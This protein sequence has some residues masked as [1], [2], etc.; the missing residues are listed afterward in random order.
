MLSNSP[1]FNRA[2]RTAGW[3]WLAY[4]IVLA[5]VDLALYTGEPA[6]SIVEFHLANFVPAVLFLGLAYTRW[7]KNQPRV[8]IPLL[9]FLNSAVPILLTYLLDLKLPSGPLTNLEGVVFRQLPVLTIG[10]VLVAWRYPIGSMLLFS[11][12]V[13]LLEGILVVLFNRSTD[14]RFIAVDIILAIRTISFLVVG[15]FINQLVSQ[16]RRQAVRD[17]LTGLFNRHYMNEFLGQVLAR[18]ARDKSEVSLVMI[19][20]DCFKRLNDAY[21]HLA[22]DAVLRSVGRLLEKHTRQGDIA[23]RFGGEEFLLVLPGAKL[24][25]AFRRADDLR[26][27]L[28]QAIFH[29]ADRPLKVTCSAG[30]AAFPEHGDSAETVLNAADDALYAAKQAGRNRVLCAPVGTPDGL[31]S[32]PGALPVQSENSNPPSGCGPA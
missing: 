12:A 24:A 13:N 21:G 5:G 26:G 3:I 14:P 1:E 20:I 7:V 18:A 8:L 9:I 29:H 16:L 32:L 31:H 17:S 27:L 10:L 23:C 4:V 19:D 22:G 11:L 2:V 28:D 30:V 25:D 15:I 6:V